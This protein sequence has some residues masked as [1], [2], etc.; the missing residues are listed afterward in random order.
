MNRLTARARFTLLVA[1]G[2]IAAVCAVVLAPPSA[3]ATPNFPPTM[4]EHLALGDYEPACSVCHAG[5]VR[6]YDTV[7]TPFGRAL[8]L[9]GLVAEDDASLRRALDALD[10]ESIDSDHDTLPDIEEIMA[11]TDPNRPASFTELAPASSYGCSAS[12][13]DR[14]GAVSAGLALI[15]VALLGMRRAWRRKRAGTQ[16]RD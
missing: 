12:R 10:R 6:A 11:G 14:D 8:R 2:A 1:L 9:N 15:G 13:I 7:F 16:T 4:R 3:L 5:D